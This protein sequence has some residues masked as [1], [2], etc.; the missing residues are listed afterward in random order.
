MLNGS[1]R[2]VRLS[3]RDSAGPSVTDP[4]RK[5][6]GS[7]LMEQCFVGDGET[8]FRQDGLRCSLE[9]PLS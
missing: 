4:Q 7:I 8:V 9:L 6:F 3:W 1:D 2:K 5:G